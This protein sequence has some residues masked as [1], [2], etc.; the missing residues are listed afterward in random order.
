MSRDG[1][2]KFCGN[3]K[4]L[5]EAHIIPK[6]FYQREGDM[7]FSL[8][9]ISKAERPRRSQMGSWDNTIL[10]APCEDRFSV[11][12]DYAAKTL[13]KRRSEARPVLDG[14]Y[15][16]K[17]EVGRPLAFELPWIDGERVA[18]FALFVLWRAGA[19]SRPECK[20][21]KLG[22]FQ[23]EIREVLKTGIRK[24]AGRLHVTLWWE[25][26]ERLRGGVVFP[27]RS[28]LEGARLW[29]FWCGGYYFLIQTDQ[30]PNR[31]DNMPN[32]LKT[33]ANVVAICT[34]FLE[35]K[36]GQHSVRALRKTNELFGDP[37]KRRPAP[38]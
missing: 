22:P 27:Y 35:H 6:A 23:E 10:C 32:V 15:A 12:D 4:P 7:P 21:V 29:N 28:R 17:D 16:A 33:G 19:S 36:V 34:T 3:K 18:L 26:N 24:S 9:N 1:C 14:A 38:H 31:F 30:R 8:I 2:S 13:L 25:S 37:W 11:V 20:G 5:V